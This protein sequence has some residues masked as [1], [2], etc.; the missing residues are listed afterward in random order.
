MIWSVTTVKSIDDKFLQ[1]AD[2]IAVE[3]FIIFHEYN[4]QKSH[5]S[6]QDNGTNN[7]KYLQVGEACL[8]RLKKK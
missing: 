7:N 6:F 2:F 4:L 1:P 3:M 8:G 5:I